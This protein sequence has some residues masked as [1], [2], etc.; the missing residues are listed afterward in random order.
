MTAPEIVIDWAALKSEEA[1]YDVLLPQL[2][3]PDWHGRNLNALWDSVGVGHINGIEP[4]YRI[5][6]RGITEVPDGLADFVRRVVVVLLDA[7]M[8]RDGIEVT[9]GDTQRGV[10]HGAAPDSTTT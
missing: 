9:F 1:F 3:A 6:M 2:A 8:V 10:Q 4:P 7:A 5:V